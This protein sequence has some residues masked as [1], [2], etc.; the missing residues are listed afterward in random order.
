MY[1]L[2]PVCFDTRRE[3][4]HGTDYIIALSITCL[5]VLHFG[6]R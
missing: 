5:G 3:F 2:Y 4:P 6:D 1:P